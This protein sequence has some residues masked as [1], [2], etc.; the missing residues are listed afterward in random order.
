MSSSLAGT[1]LSHLSSRGGH[2]ALTWYGADGGRLELSGYVVANWIT[3]TTNLLVDEFSADDGTTVAIDLPAH[4]R[5]LCWVLSSWHVGAQV[6]LGPDAAGQSI[7]IV[8]TSRPELWQRADAEVLAVALPALARRFPDPLPAGVIDAGPAVMGC[9]DVL[10]WVPQPVAQQTALTLHDADVTYGELPHW[11]EARASSALN[12]AAIAE[13]RVII[14]CTATEVT[15]SLLGTLVGCW[16]GGA[17]AIVVEPG[18]AAAA[19]LSR[20]TSNEYADQVIT[21]E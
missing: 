7:D 17:A 12:T 6:V 16:L 1:V 2:P 21:L 9:S 14:V 18:A 4:W 15:P 10:G 5:T 20:L 3:K 11:L 13:R 8:A 19:D